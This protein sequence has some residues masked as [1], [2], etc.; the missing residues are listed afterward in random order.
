MILGAGKLQLPAILKAKEMGLEVIAVDMDK[1]AVGFDYADINLEISTIDIEKVLAA[2]KK[3]E[4]NGIM[5][6]ASD[7]PIRTVACVSKELNLVGV[8]EDVALKATNKAIMR[9]ILSE[10]GVSC[11]LFYKVS[12][13][14][15]FTEA[16]NHIT[17]KGVKC[18]IK[19][20]DNSG[21]RGVKLLDDCDGKSL[22]ESYEYSRSFSRCGDVI[23]EEYMDGH[24]VSVEIL[25]MDGECN[26]VAVTD[27]ITTGSPYFVEMGHSQPSRLSRT[28]LDNIESLAKRAV[29]VI[30]INN[31][32]AHV[33]VMLVND[34]NEAKI[35]EIGARL[36]GDNITTHL[37]PLSTGVDMVESCI[38]IALGD[39]PDIR[40][41]MDKG[42]AIKYFCT[43]EGVVEDIIGIEPALKL[44][45]V[46]NIEI[47]CKVGDH[48]PEIKNSVDRIG[49][50]ITTGNNYEEALSICNEAL[51][52]ISIKIS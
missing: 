46:E 31:G 5:T 14:D 35:V 39:K 48:I 20:V 49:Y 1:N 40:P 28:N 24:E 17:G 37:V 9:Q 52:M 26:V 7:M 11:P 47:N 30:G 10:H 33:E 42:S 43:H 4:I 25:C 3:Y 16:V 38:K 36:G 27:K 8:S 34:T 15:E 45:G 50:V 12:N 51:N 18:I 19:P 29:E 22:Y 2:A 41:S 23:V 21:S 32:A 44:E 6:I 13:F